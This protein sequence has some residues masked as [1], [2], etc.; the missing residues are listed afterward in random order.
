VTLFVGLA[1]GGAAFVSIAG[2]LLEVAIL[3]RLLVLRED[4][5]ADEGD[6]DLE[7]ETEDNEWRSRNLPRLGGRV[8]VESFAVNGLHHDQHFP[9]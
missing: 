8:G 1:F 6:L 7:R 3:T 9:E 5:V 2:R 4:A